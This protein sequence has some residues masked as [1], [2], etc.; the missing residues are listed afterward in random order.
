M[1]S[2]I[3]QDLLRVSIFCLY[4]WGLIVL[5]GPKW[6]PLQIEGK[7]WLP[8]GTAKRD[9]YI[10]ISG[11]KTPNCQRTP[12]FLSIRISAGLLTV[13][14]DLAGVSGMFWS[15]I[16]Q[17]WAETVEMESPFYFE[18]L[19]NIQTENSNKKWF[20]CFGL[21]PTFPGHC[22]LRHYLFP[23]AGLKWFWG[24]SSRRKAGGNAFTIIIYLPLK[25]LIICTRE[26]KIKIVWQLTKRFSKIR[27]TFS[28][29][30]IYSVLKIPASSF[31][32]LQKLLTS[33]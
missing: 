15:R 30:I 13:C 25:R 17:A 14:Q 20:W 29:E 5:P 9:I 18:Y 6:G 31:L 28:K 19:E 33:H 22:T 8:S 26:G 1:R 2:F 11:F 12:L 10:W 16:L 4:S 32:V 7:P 21:T 3:L 24:A 23:P 27:S